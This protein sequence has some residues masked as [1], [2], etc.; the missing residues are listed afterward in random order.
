M[1]LNA[2]KAGHKQTDLPHG[3]V[4]FITQ[5]QLRMSAPVDGRPYAN[6]AGEN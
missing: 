3:K 2:P 6:S 5:A 4:R 1:K